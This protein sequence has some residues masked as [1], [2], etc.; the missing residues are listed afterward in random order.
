M[1]H[2]KFTPNG[3]LP[4]LRVTD[5][6]GRILAEFDGPRLD[7]TIREGKLSCADLLDTSPQGQHRLIRRLILLAC[8]QSCRKGMACLAVDCPL[9]PQHRANSPTTLSAAAA[10]ISHLKNRA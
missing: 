9:H 3:D 5:D 2:L 4:S 6:G 7:Q 8:A 10:G 1:L